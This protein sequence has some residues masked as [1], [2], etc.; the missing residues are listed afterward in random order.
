[1]SR[2][3]DGFSLLE[4]IVAIAIIGII[5]AISVAVFVNLHNTEAL[6][7]DASSISSL[8][9]TARVHSLSSKNNEPY[10][11]YIEDNESMVF[12]GSTFDP[13]NVITRASLHSTVQF[14]EITLTNSTSTVLFD[15]IT[16][17]TDNHGVIVLESVRRAASSTVSIEPTGSITTDF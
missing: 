15:K 2:N 9:E 5:T 4:I 14:D 1:M 13:N 3:T 6:R 8:L 11:V 16:G 12:S 10:G 7:R 17:A